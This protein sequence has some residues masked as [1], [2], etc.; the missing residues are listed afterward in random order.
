M[1]AREPR[2]KAADPALMLIPQTGMQVAM[3]NFDV[4]AND[5]ANITSSNYRPSRLHAT[6]VPGRSGAMVASVQKE[7]D[8]PGTDLAEEMVELVLVGAA[9][10]ANAAALRTQD[11][12]LGSLVDVLA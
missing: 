2:P 11:E 10:G 6:E 8:K 12:M 5:I 7:E 4:T 3:A 1:K 9:Y